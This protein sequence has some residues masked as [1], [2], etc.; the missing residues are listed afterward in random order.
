MNH[1]RTIYS[2]L[3]G[4]I[5]TVA[6]MAFALGPAQAGGPTPSPSPSSSTTSPPPTPTSPPPTPGGNW[7]SPG[8]WR[9]NP[10]AVA[11]TGVDMTQSYNALFNPDLAGNPTLQQVLDNPQTYGG[12]AFNNV[13][14]LLSA[15]H[16]GVDFQGD[17]VE[18]SCP[19]SAD[20][21]ND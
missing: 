17:R 10:G 21:A 16:P 13:A 14:D 8:F 11:E 7:C 12:A 5:T 9:N 19:L 4:V 15:A 20:E 18:D 1:K 3:A 2:V 6:C